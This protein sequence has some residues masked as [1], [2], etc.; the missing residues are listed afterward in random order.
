MINDM[1]IQ[2]G[3]DNQRMG[4]LL[5]VAIRRGQDRPDEYGKT[6]GQ[7]VKQGAVTTRLPFATWFKS[8]LMSPNAK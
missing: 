3:T 4:N 1:S 5:G 6:D 7:D 2:V 8:T